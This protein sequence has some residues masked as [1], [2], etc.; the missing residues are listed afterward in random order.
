LLNVFGQIATFWEIKKKV[1]F[2]HDDL[3]SDRYIDLVRKQ[4][5]FDI[6]Y[7][8]T[9]IGLHTSIALQESDSMPD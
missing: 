6:S 2:A 7:Q 9:H 8:I 1:A 5:R 4:I 3:L